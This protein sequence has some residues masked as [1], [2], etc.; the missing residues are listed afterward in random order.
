M[1]VEALVPLLKDL[2]GATALNLIVGSRY[3]D[4][5]LFG[6]TTDSSVKLEWRPVQDLLIR[7]SWSEVFRSPQVGDLF[8]GKFAN[9]PTFNDPCVGLTAAEVAANPNLAVPA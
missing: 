9:A 7:A 5:N 8:G 3:S 2:P 1:Y 4:F 6:D